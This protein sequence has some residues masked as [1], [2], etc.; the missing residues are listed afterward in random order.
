[1]SDAS[2]LPENPLL[3]PTGIADFQHFRAEHVVPGVQA[4]LR[5]SEEQLVELEQESSATWDGIVLGLER[6]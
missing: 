4:M 1:M 6:L 2:S 5:W 3:A